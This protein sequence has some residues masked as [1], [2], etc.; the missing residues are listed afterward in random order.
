[1]MP[2]MMN[3]RT[4]D[5]ARV[6]RESRVSRRELEYMGDRLS[7]T[8]IVDQMTGDM[9][10]RMHMDILKGPEKEVKR[11]TKT[12]THTEEIKPAPDWN[13][14]ELLHAVP[15]TPW[16]YFKA[17]V[18]SR[19]G[20][21]GRWWLKRWPVEVRLIGSVTKMVFGPTTINH[22]TN[23]TIEITRETRTCRHIAVPHGDYRDQ[24]LR[25][26]TFDVGNPPPP[27]RPRPFCPICMSPPDHPYHEERC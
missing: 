12:S 14:L 17:E 10:L 6:A 8:A 7:T 15:A 19:L 24:H 16:D 26:L 4:V 3:V 21:F 27:P 18:V 20:R 9:I 25:F 23:T 2:S 5:V 1:M 22:T 11:E 13:F